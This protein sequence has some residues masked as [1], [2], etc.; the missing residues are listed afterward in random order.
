MYS[1]RLLTVE[2]D[3]YKF[4]NA[5]TSADDNSV[6]GISKRYRH[7]QHNMRA[8]AIR[9]SKGVYKIPPKRHFCDQIMV[10]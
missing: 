1:C 10:M 6:L 2:E 8:T 4:T 3:T 7:V 9:A 5:L